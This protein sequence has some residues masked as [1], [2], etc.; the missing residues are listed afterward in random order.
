MRKG[1]EENLQKELAEILNTNTSNISNLKSWEGGD[2]LQPDV[3]HQPDAPHQ[4]GVLQQPGRLRP[5]RIVLPASLVF[6]CLPLNT[7]TNGGL[8]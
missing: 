1:F 4:P 3:L 7:W 8:R 5:L 6:N 2:E